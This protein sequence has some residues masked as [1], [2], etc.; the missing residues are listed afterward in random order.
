MAVPVLYGSTS[1]QKENS[2]GVEKMYEWSQNRRRVMHQMKNLTKFREMANVYFKHCSSAYSVSQHHHFSTQEFM[3]GD[4][5]RGKKK[6]LELNLHSTPGW[7]LYLSQSILSQLMVPAPTP[8]SGCSPPPTACFLSLHLTFNA[9]NSDGS[10]SQN[11][12]H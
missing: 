7:H 2:S 8:L 9:A 1:L 11:I 12:S 10:T 3:G 4:R 6:L 5:Y